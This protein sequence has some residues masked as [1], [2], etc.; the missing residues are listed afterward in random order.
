[1][2]NATI[3]KF[4]HPATC[5]A[6]YLHWVVLVRPQAVT[7]GS[8]VIAA[9]SE[10]TA[11]GELHPAA[12][13]ELAAVIGQVE[14]ALFAFTAYEKLNYMMLMMV[15]PHVHFHVFPRYEGIRSFE[16][17]VF[18]DAGWPNIPVLADARTLNP[19]MIATTVEALRE[20][21][22]TGTAPPPRS[23]VPY[24]TACR[25]SSV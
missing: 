13:T 24:E 20:C 3:A 22:L 16:G 18:P 25:S 2:I 4:G 5:I 1:M 9:R 6:E 14:H 17:D 21:G 11:F 15:D 12:F 8:L 19:A 10:A 7:L 23:L